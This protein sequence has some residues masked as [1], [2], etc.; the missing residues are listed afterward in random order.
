M[1]YFIANKKSKI[2]IY[3]YSVNGRTMVRNLKHHSGNIVAFFDRNSK[4]LKNSS[5]IKILSTKEGIDYFS[6]QLNELIIIISIANVFEHR[7]IAMQ[8]QKDGFQNIIFFPD[9]SFNQRA[10]EVKQ[11]R[12]VFKRVL[13]GGG[14]YGERLLT[15]TALKKH[16]NTL[17]IEATTNSITA[18]IPIELIHTGDQQIFLEN[19]Q[20]SSAFDG[21]R[22][23]GICGELEKLPCYFNTPLAG[24]NYYL[25]LY[26]FFQG[27]NESG[28]DSYFKWKQAMNR[29][30]ELA[31]RDRKRMLEDRLSVYQNMA[32]ALAVND[33]FFR[34]NPV[35]LKFNKEG[36]FYLVNGANRSCFY[37]N[38]GLRF[39]PAKLDIDSYNTWTKGGLN[40]NE[41][42]CLLE[43]KLL[44]QYPIN[45]HPVLYTSAPSFIQYQ[46]YLKICRFISANAIN[47]V[48]SK[49]LVINSTNSYFSM[50]FTRI[51]AE[52]T[53][54]VLNDE[55]K[56]DNA[57]IN[58]LCFS[59]K[60]NI[61]TGNLDKI[62][63][64]NNYDIIAYLDENDAIWKSPEKEI[65]FIRN[66][67]ASLVFWIC[68]SGETA[69]RFEKCF[70]DYSIERLGQHCGNNYQY[71]NAY[72][73][74]KREMSK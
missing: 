8:L 29:G 57:L 27:K 33:N 20:N 49:V 51:K 14:F 25:D 12:D 67:T 72:A 66:S 60:I 11:M 64:K 22:K 40:V 1:S 36:Y 61:I 7:S 52:T 54:H 24:F 53:S 38:K 47:L 31:D 21:L 39:I 32:D 71:Y 56:E 50:F 69:E 62:A 37:L 48:N 30:M 65:T 68:R 13:E 73:L 74:Y 58:K 6:D 70:K 4:Q 45:I 5:E 43:S 46:K 3:G 42:Q 34:L 35:E 63:I 16:L 55:F 19:N 9:F 41:K 15:F 28:C 10:A 59:K 44:Q 26:D 2:V 23:S 18:L 17:F